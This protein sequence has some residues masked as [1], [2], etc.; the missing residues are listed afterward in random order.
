MWLSCLYKLDPADG[1]HSGVVWDGSF[2][3]AACAVVI[4][5]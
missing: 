1:V 5:G 4:N 3:R 2:E